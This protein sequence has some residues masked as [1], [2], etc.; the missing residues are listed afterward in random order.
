MR[1]SMQTTHFTFITTPGCDTW[2]SK[3]N[4][5]QVENVGGRFGSPSI[6]LTRLP[7]TLE[8]RRT[9]SV[10][11]LHKLRRELERRRFDCQSQKYARRA[12]HRCPGQNSRGNGVHSTPAK[13]SNAP[14]TGTMAGGEHIFRNGQDLDG[15]VKV[16]PWT[17]DAIGKADVNTRGRAFCRTALTT[18]AATPVSL[19]YLSYISH[20]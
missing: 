9:W 20:S 2:C 18:P 17:S 6:P 8:A 13:R 16:T 12:I 19:L 3:R 4:T 15:L 14:A 10:H 11:Q 1:R 7:E 5:R